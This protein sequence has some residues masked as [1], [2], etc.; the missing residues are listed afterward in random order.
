MTPGYEDNPAPV[1]AGIIRYRV[2]Y[3]GT[4][5]NM[6]VR[7]NAT[8]AGGDIVYTAQINGVNTA[9]TVTLNGSASDGSDLVNTVAIAAGDLISIEVNTTS[10]STPSP[11]E[12]YVVVELS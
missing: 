3:A 7:H 10:M 11:T 5:R 9:L 1:F 8:G 6:R 4:L 12:V 2:L